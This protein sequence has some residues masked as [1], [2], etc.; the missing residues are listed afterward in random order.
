MNSAFSGDPEFGDL[1]HF[2][3]EEIQK[4]LY[5]SIARIEVRT[6]NGG[7]APKNLD[8]EKYEKEPD[9]IGLRLIAI[10]GMSLSRGLTLEEL[11]TFC[12]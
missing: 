12:L 3:W 6:I 4:N 11:Q 10:G 8:Y 2:T 5:P 9:D 1:K 7:N